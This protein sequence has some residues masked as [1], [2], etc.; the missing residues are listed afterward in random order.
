[1]IDFGS[2]AIKNKGLVYFLVAVLM[3]GGAYSCYTMSKLEDPE[4]KIKMAMVVNTY[5]GDS[6]H[7]VEMEVTDVLEKQ[8]RAMGDVDNI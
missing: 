6:A 1:M 8:I 7:Q 3:V 2:W 5:P 4:I